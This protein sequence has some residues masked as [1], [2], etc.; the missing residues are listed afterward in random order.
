MTP[1]DHGTLAATFDDCIRQGLGDG[2]TVHAMT[3]LILE[4]GMDSELAVDEA[5]TTFRKLAVP[6]V[7]GTHWWNGRTGSAVAADAWAAFMQ[8]PEAQGRNGA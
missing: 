6:A 4:Q 2:D 8:S 5:Y 1:A 7:V 3:A